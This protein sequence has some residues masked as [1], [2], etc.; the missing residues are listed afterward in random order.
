MQ[1]ALRILLA[2]ALVS[3]GMAA[4][5]ADVKPYARDFL[6]SDAVHFA[7]TARKETAGA[8]ALIKGK[9]PEQ[10]RNEA[11]A[12]GANGDFKLAGRLAAAAIAGN[13]KDAANWLA[14]ARL[15]VK[16]DDAQSSERYELRERGSTAAY[17]AYERLAPP[18]PQAQALAVLADLFARR[19]MWRPALDAYRASLD[20]HDDLDIRKTYEDLREKHGF[21]I[22]DYKVDNDSA[23]PR[24]CFQFSEP[25][26]RKTDFAPYVA[27][28]GAANGAISAEEQ[29]LCVEGLRHGERYA[30]VVRQGLPSTVGESLLKDADYEIYVRDRSAQVHFTGKNY[31]LPRQGQ[32]GAPLV[33]VNTAKVA[34]DVYRIGDRNL[35]ATVQRDD[36]LKDIGSSRA[37]E[38]ADQDGV[39]IWSGSMDVASELNKD[40]VTEFPVLEAVGK[41]DPGV[42]VI[43]ARPWKGGDA[44]AKP[45]GDDSESQLATQWLVIS[46]LGLTALSGGD[47]V[48]AIIHSLATAAPLVGVQ[49]KLLARNNEILA[50]KATGADG[51]ADFDPGL[52]RGTGGLSP[53]LLVATTEGGDY[54]FLNL[55]QN[56]FDLTDRGVSGREAP[57]ALDAFL[58]TERGVY[59]SGETVF[60]T[61]L[62]RDAQGAA[63]AGL[64]LTLV[65]LRPDG[66][67]YKR[68]VI[69]DQGL[70]GRSMTLPLLA[71]AQAG[72]WRIVAYVD[73]KGPSVGE[74]QFMLE[75]YIPER[76][77]VK[78]KPAAEILTPGEPVQIAVDAKFLYGA[79]AAGL[80][81]TGQISL[82]AVQRLGDSRLQRL[83]GRIDRRRVHRGQQPVR[84]QAADRRQGPCRHFRRPARGRGS[85]AAPGEDH[86]R[87]RR[88]RR[89]HRRTR[90]HPAGARQDDSDRRQEGIRR[91]IVGRR[92]G[93][94]RSDRRRAGRFARRAQGRRMVAVQDR[95]QL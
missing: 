75:D 9:S 56:A 91:G 83:R 25:L 7:E 27:V 29:Q 34:L 6:A 46:D 12:A 79:V 47:G 4:R 30:I 54:G 63:K 52:S 1:A 87:C 22:T 51:R 82:Q 42:Y 50:T 64:P 89:P 37:S 31:V 61:A 8:A 71:G 66:V 2:L 62:L 43:T 74:T 36:F 10:L 5:A 69:A 59:R 49:V 77:D 84:L 13:P 70:G 68:A 93:D 28:S 23:A 24:V 65:A 76:L 78:I 3:A 44:A 11:A 19:E 92:G 16:A 94:I 17:A 21:R 14:L 18:G 80:D 55:A 67:E 81:V 58:F 48:H 88:A 53:G 35:L 41:L 86:R 39:K 33:T 32:Q 15:A 60:V 95:L 90:R 57:K 45:E 72:S 26:A 20:R 40:V 73:P 85:Q 38:I